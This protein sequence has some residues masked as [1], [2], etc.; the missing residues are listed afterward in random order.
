M[1]N[2][3]EEIKL[4]DYEKH[5]SLDSVKQ[6]QTMNKM[7][8]EQLEAYPVTETTVPKSGRDLM[9]DA[10]FGWHTWIW[11]RLQKEKGKANVYL[12]YFDQHPEY[13]DAGFVYHSNNVRQRRTYHLPKATRSPCQHSTGL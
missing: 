9:R 3:W 2:P 7:M 4:Y 13:P 8:K 10:A 1:N 11:C 6:L 5:M 12:Y